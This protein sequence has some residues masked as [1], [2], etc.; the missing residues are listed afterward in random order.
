VVERAS[1]GCAGYGGDDSGIARRREGFWFKGQR[2]L[3]KE[4]KSEIRGQ[5]RNIETSN[6]ERPIAQDPAKAKS[7]E[8]SV[9]SR[10]AQLGL[11]LSPKS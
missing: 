4:Q 3:V 8:L 5:R 6:G 9:R 1:S 2:S 11:E 7:G 10:A